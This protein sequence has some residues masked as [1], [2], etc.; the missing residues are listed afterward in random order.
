M[1]RGD[2]RV[3]NYHAPME[4]RVDGRMGALRKPTLVTLFV[5]G[6]VAP[7][8]IMLLAPQPAARQWWRDGAVAL[9]FL[10]FAL[11]GW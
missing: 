9:G 3:W 10:G 8:L 7:I 6:S 11:M 4:R 2:R 5:L 1:T